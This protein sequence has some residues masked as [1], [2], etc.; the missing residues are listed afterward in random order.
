M[1]WTV[2]LGGKRCRPLSV[3]DRGLHRLLGHS[4][5]NVWGKYGANYIYIYF[6]LY[7]V[8]YWHCYCKNVFNT[9]RGYQCL[10]TV[11]DAIF[12]GS[13]FRARG[14]GIVSRW[15]T[16]RAFLVVGPVCGANICECGLYFVRDGGAVFRFGKATQDH[17][18]TYGD[19]YSHLPFTPNCRVYC[20]AVSIITCCSPFTSLFSAKNT[21]ANN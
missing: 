19:V 2:R 18:E 15:I 1:D 7:S 9:L 3:S 4:C 14:P 16:V 17:G 13:N 6:F 20:S 12:T 5:P 8:S 10:F 21:V 11:D